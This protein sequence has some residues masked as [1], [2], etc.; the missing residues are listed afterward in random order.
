[1]RCLDPGPSVG[2]PS[3]GRLL[4]ASNESDTADPDEISRRDPKSGRIRVCRDDPV[5]RKNTAERQKLLLRI[6]ST[7]RPEFE[8]PRYRSKMDRSREAVRLPM[9]GDASVASPAWNIRMTSWRPFKKRTPGI[10]YASIHQSVL[11]SLRVRNLSPEAIRV[12]LR[13]N[14]DWGPDNP[15]RLSSTRLP[16]NSR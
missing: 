12:F 13:A 8:G 15:L 10:P 2:G 16:V 7:E 5:R 6:R 11:A 3:A 1:V 9:A 4:S 14:A